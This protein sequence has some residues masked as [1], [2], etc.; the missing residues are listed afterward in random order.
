MV[1][2]R[3]QK[4]RDLTKGNIYKNFLF[5]SFPVVFA[6][7]ISM[8]Q[9]V[10]DTSIAGKYLNEVGLASVGAMGA[11]VQIFS[12]L[13]W[14]MA[15][16]FC[17]Y[18]AR[19]FGSGDMVKLKNDIVT[20]IILSTTLTVAVGAIP[21]IFKD[22]LYDFMNVDKSI[23]PTTDT[24]FTL[25]IIGLVFSQ[26]RIL[27]VHYMHALG[28]TRFPFLVTIIATT[29]NVA[30]AILGVSKLDMGVAGIALAAI[31][32]NIIANA[33]L[34]VYLFK[35]L[36]KGGAPKG[37]TF[38]KNLVKESH[39]YFLPNGF[40]QL[41]MYL[42]SALL[43]PIINGIS[44]SATAGYTVVQRVYNI[45]ANIYQ[46]S[47]KTVSNYCAQSIGA[48]NTHKI[49]KGLLAGLFQGLMYVS[50]PLSATVFFAKDICLL[51]FPDNFAGESLKI[52][53]LFCHYFA[54]LILFNLINNLFHAFVRGTGEMK[55]LFISSLLGALL[56][57][58]LSWLFA[59]FLQLEMTGIFIGWALSW[60]LEAVFVFV[61]F[62]VKYRNEKLLLK[63]IT[64]RY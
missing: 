25:T 34:I 46:S 35:S 19:I 10:I 23:L 55:M 4:M 47:A 44:A 31:T 22:F 45:N 18:I 41:C 53:V 48:G 27:L 36:K 56:N 59:Y 1:N 16:G 11:T 38:N 37:F 60:I 64:K 62:M 8:L 21:L 29:V 30:L 43:S 6:S 58:A 57:C 42:A 49:H 40:Q 32:S 26:L 51:F 7:V 14:G 63:A 17:V 50:I 13:L 52:A 61:V 2:R 9:Q 3:V 54:P 15:V 12:S 24:Y 39:R 28:S 5:F 33:L 20:G